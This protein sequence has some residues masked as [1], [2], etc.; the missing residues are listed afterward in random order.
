MH[1]NISAEVGANIRAEMARRGVAQMTLAAAV[2][3]SQSGLSKRLRGHT[4]LGVD[5]LLRIAAYLDVPAYD[6]IPDHLA[7]QRASA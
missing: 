6:L 2:G 4:P 3:V 1:T 5:E 7:P